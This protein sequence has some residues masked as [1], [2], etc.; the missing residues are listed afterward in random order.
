MP[1]DTGPYLH[2]AAIREK[3]L[4]EGRD[5]AG[6]YEVH[7]QDEEHDRAKCPAKKPA[8]ISVEQSSQSRQCRPPL[9]PENPRITGSEKPAGR[10]ASEYTAHYS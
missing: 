9:P 10:E 4:R 7:D 1:Q 5:A 3:V 2:Y 6:S 8:G